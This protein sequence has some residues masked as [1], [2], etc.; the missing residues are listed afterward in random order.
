MVRHNPKAARV[1]MVN[2]A[3]AED[4]LD[5]IMGNLLLNSFTAKVLFDSGASY[6]FLSC[7]FASR[8]NFDT[9]S[10]PRALQVISPAKCLTSSL[11]APDVHIK[12]GN[13]SFLADPIVLGNSDIDLIFGMDWL[14]KHKATLD[15]AA[16][17]VQ[18][19]HPSEKVIIFVARD[20]TIRLFSLNER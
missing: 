8:H 18:L 9:K 12:M 5:V 20:D 11:V 7:P 6:S 3:Q 14:S 19:T 13:Y 4:S 17:E 16:K 2:S 15:C 10:L 1:D